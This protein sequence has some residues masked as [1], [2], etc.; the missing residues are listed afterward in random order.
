MTPNAK[1]VV[2]VAIVFV[3]CIRKSLLQSYA[4]MVSCTWFLAAFG[5]SC[6]AVPYSRPGYR[7]RFLGLAVVTLTVL[8]L[9]VNHVIG[10]SI[11]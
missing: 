8:L 5:M 4:N 2:A 10:E 1:M 3:T 6:F 9:R 7:V 11:G